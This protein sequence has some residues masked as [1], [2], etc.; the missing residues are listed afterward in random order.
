MTTT[1]IATYANGQ[2]LASTDIDL[3]VLLRRKLVP[4]F[5]GRIGYVAW[6]RKQDTATVTA[7]SRSFYISDNDFWHM[8]KLVISGEES[9]GLT[10]IGD[11]EEKVLKAVANGTAAK[12]T[13]YYMEL[14]TNISTINWRVIFDSPLDVDRTFAYIYDTNIYFSNDSTSVD[15]DL[16]IPTQFQWGLV[17]L[18]QAEVYATRFG[19]GDESRY[20]RAMDEAEKFIAMAM[21]SPDLSRGGRP[22]YI[23]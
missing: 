12:P 8:K 14:S 6:R 19:A 1:Q 3:Q 10:Y 23:S 16:Y 21:E 15:L 18:L 13:Q 2:D 17:H 22:R 4:Y 7:G 5:L 9:K 20:Q 11:D